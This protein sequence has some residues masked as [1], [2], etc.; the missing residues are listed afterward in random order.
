MTQLSLHRVTSDDEPELT[1]R[2]VPEILDS[3]IQGGGDDCWIQIVGVKSNATSPIGVGVDV[4]YGVLAPSK[5]GAHAVVVSDTD[6]DGAGG[7]GDIGV[8]VL[9]ALFMMDGLAREI[10]AARRA[11]ATAAVMNGIKRRENAIV[12]VT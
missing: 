6:D 1:V 5:G 2:E 12:R 7:D 4:L 10:E 9:K 11:G 8:R 3:S